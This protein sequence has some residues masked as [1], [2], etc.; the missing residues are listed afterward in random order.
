[1]TAR[2]ALIQANKGGDFFVS[3]GAVFDEATLKVVKLVIHVIKAFRIYGL[4]YSY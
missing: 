2:N 3:N 4:D 1:M